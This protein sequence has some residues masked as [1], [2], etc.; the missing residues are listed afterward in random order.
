VPRFSLCL[1]ILWLPLIV[2]CE[3]CR[4]DKDSGADD[5]KDKAPLEDFSTKLPSVFPADLNPISGGIKPGHWL[6]ASQPLKSNKIDARGELLSRATVKGENFQSGDSKTI[7]GR[8][9]T[10]RPVVL[11]K[12]QLRRFDYRMLAPMPPALDEKKCY[13]NS[14]FVSS[15][16]AT[17]YDTGQQPFNVLAGQEFFFVVLTQRPERFAKFQVASWIEPPRDKYKFQNH[18][19]NYRII[20]PPVDDV[21]PLSE[22]MLDWTSTSVLFWDDLSPDA[23]T[24]AQ[25]NAIA[26]WVRFGGHLIV[27]GAAASDAIADTTLA[28]LL[29]LKPTGNIELDPTA[30][31]E[32]LRGHAVKDDPSTEKQISLVKDQSARL[33]VDGI[34]ADDASAVANSGK[35]IL[36]RMIGRGRVIQARFDVTSDWLSNWESYDSFVNG[37]LLRRPRRRYVKPDENSAL[38]RTYPDRS[39]GPGDPTLNTQFRIAARDAILPIPVVPTSAEPTT[40]QSA[41]A[42]RHDRLTRI[43]SMSGVSGW[44]DYSD[45][46]SICQQI[47][48][49]ESGIEIPDSSLVIRSL[50]Y[51]LLI[52]V[53]INYLIF[54]LLGR[55]EYAWLAVPLIAIGGA[56]W[57]AR[58]TR[59]DIGFA[60]SQTQIAMVELQPGY[61]RGHLSRVIAIYNSLTSSY[62]IEFNTAGAAAAPID[63]TIDTDS[64]TVFKTGFAEG[65]ILAGVA[66]DSNQVRMLHTEQMVDMGG[67][68]DLTDDGQLVNRTSH[69]LLDA[70]VVE[71][72]D[73]GDVQVSSLGQC[74][75]GSAVK[76]RR[77]KI[78]TISVGNDLPMQTGRFLRRLASPAGMYNGT[79]RL[80]ARIDSSLPGMTITPEANQAMSQTVVLAHLKHRPIRVAE[81]D[82][83][84]ISQFVDV[85]TDEDESEAEAP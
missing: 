21:L 81:V 17:F 49:D 37:A 25:Q 43:Q 74:D 79:S 24:P 64:D 68:I 58:A 45:A 41:L 39:F 38:Q 57:V 29:P 28:N 33:A 67:S 16:R 70:Y 10:V 48:R 51:Y 13:L 12:G 36:E 54:R 46:L 71:K 85:L 9:P 82:E 72:S 26:D 19:P 60:R 1:L 11:P 27:N 73:A 84:L 52:L 3:G 44:T 80:V 75:S 77:K 66:V 35:L 23:L 59:L 76:L 61:G 63:D 53:P 22:T 6:T 50:G 83:N 69:T 32:L 20:V 30:A 7:D 8:I 4:G 47:L 78:E 2:G 31:T 15:G 56:V 65:P 42:S 34:A 5:E 40:T 55:L 62:D 14:R 18:D